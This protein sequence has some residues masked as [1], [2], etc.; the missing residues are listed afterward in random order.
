MSRK[1]KV[2]AQPQEVSG[3]AALI[4]T[5][6]IEGYEIKE[7]NIRNFS[8]LYPYL[9]VV[10]TECQKH[11]AT[12]DNMDEFLDKDF[13]IIIDAI[14]PVLPEILA[15]SLN[16]TQEQADEIPAAKAGVLTMAILKRNTEHLTSFLAQIRGSLREATTVPQTSEWRTSHGISV[17]LSETV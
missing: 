16:L 9:K 5:P 3:I 15:L 13:G 7:W 2:K 10:V 14:V 4:D 6:V 11:G 8:H 12:I 1:P 17:T